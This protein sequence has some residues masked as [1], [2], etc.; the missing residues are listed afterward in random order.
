METSLHLNIFNFFFVAARVEA[1]IQWDMSGLV[2]I[3]RSILS[4]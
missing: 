4:R 1:A 2:T 3:N